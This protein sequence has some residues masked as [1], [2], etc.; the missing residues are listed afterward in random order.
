MLPLLEIHCIKRIK[1]KYLAA[2]VQQ[3]RQNKFYVLDWFKTGFT[4]NNGDDW[5]ILLQHCDF[6][7]F[8]ISIWLMPHWN[9]LEHWT[10]HIFHVHKTCLCLNSFRCYQFFVWCI[11]RK[12]KYHQKSPTIA[13][14]IPKLFYNPIQ[15]FMI[16]VV[17]IIAWKTNLQ[18]EH[19]PKRLHKNNHFK[20]L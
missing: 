11:K 16:A 7:I 3:R 14:W 2:F 5:F 17:V 20:I 4:D 8:R 15:S 9:S 18:S 10:T 19:V 6:N 1:T 13:L 12:K